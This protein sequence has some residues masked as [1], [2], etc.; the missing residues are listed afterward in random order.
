MDRFDKIMNVLISIQIPKGRP[1]RQ[2]GNIVEGEKLYQLRKIS[3]SQYRSCRE[4]F[5][6]NCSVEIAN[7]CIDMVFEVWILLASI[8]RISARNVTLS[9]SSPTPNAIIDR[10]LSFLTS[11]L[12]SFLSS[13]IVFAPGSS[14][15]PS[16]QSDF[17]YPDRALPMYWT[18]SGS[19]VSK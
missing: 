12:T 6:F 16:Y 4:V 9:K 17:V 5:P 14:S 15:N 7:P 13:T 11:F 3:T 2:I 1:E 10:S 19:S 18:I 8:L